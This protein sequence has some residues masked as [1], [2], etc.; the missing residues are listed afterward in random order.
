MPQLG[1]KA[2]LQAALLQRIQQ[3]VKV[4][5]RELLGRIP[6]GMGQFPRHLVPRD[7]V[8]D[9]AQVLQQHHA[10]GCRQRPQL[11]ERQLI[12]FLISL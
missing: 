3:L 4:L 1:E 9:A 6:D 11:T 5:F 7:P 2:A 12:D 8:R 10:K